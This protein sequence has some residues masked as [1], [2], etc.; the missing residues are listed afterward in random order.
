MANRLVKLPK[1][2]DLLSRPAGVTIKE[3]S[4]HLAIDRKSVYRLIDTIEDLPVPIYDEK[5]PGTGKRDE[6]WW[7]LIP[8]FSANEVRNILIRLKQ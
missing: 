1:A 5:L 2:L 4:E 3:F 6:S 8:K 7:T